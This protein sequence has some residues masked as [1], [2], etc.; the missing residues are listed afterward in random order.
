MN[1]AFTTQTTT[2]AAVFFVAGG[3]LNSASVANGFN[4]LAASGNITGII[5]VYGRP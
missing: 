4:V 5:K 3:Y 1:G 2:P